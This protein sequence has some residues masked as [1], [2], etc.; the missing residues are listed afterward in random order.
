MRARDRKRHSAQ[1]DAFENFTAGMEEGLRRYWRQGLVVIAAIVL[2]LL[3]YR[4]YAGKAEMERS[5]TWDEM[6]KMPVVGFYMWQGNPDDISREVISQCEKLLSERWK[7]DATPWVL[8]KLGN[9]QRALRQHEDALKTYE[10]LEREYKNSYAA[11]LAVPARAAELEETERFD[12][13]ARLYEK[14]AAEGAKHSRFWLDAGRAWELARNREK[15]INAYKNLADVKGGEE[16]DEVTLAADRLKQLTAGQPM[17]TPPPPPPPPPLPERPK[18]LPGPV[19]E[20]PKPPG[21]P[22]VE[23]EP[24]KGPAPAPA[25]AKPDEVNKPGT[26]GGAAAP[27]PAKTP[28]PAPPEKKKDLP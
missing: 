14:I 26:E 19:I 5:A 10:R 12:V 17:L 9:A 2:A 24:G 27:P 1:P 20:E 15:A 18:E 13:A 21:Q 25:P 28:E 3:G 16:R 4:A 11:W 8:L 6:D 23:P 7:T 22:P